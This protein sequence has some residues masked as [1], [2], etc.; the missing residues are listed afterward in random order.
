MA[1]E[2]QNDPADR[3]SYRARSVNDH[4]ELETAEAQ[5][6]LPDR[7]QC[8]TILEQLARIQNSKAFGNSDR[9]KQFLSYV[10]EHAVDGH[11][12]LLKERLIGVDVFH[13]SPSYIT[14][15][16]SIVRVQAAD[17]RRR[18]LHYYSEEEQEPE[19]RIEIPVGSYI[20]KFHWRCSPDSVPRPVKTLIVERNALQ[21][22]LRAWRTAVLT[23]VLVA[24]GLA[25]AIA[26]RERSKHESALEDFWAPVFKAGGPVLICLPSP[27]AAVF[28]SDFETG[29][30]PTSW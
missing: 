17:V 4:I 15:E 2:T 7:N 20:P 14:S 3:Q 22:K 18:L 29:P 26:I 9:A 28:G 8:A 30:R 6:G 19:V 23:M 10:V 24:L 25:A 13:R 12:G 16:D 21:P 1:F 11:S 27:V 5:S